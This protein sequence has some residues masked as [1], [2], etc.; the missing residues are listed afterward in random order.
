MYPTTPNDM[1]PHYLWKIEVRICDKLRTR[2]TFSW[3]VMV[4]VGISKL[5]FTDLI[6]VDPRVKINGGY[7]RSCCPWCATYQTISSSFN[8]TAHPHTRYVKTVRFLVQLTSVFIRQDLWPSNSTDINSAIYKTCGD[9]QQRV[10][11]SQLHSIDELEKRLLDVIGTKSS[12]RASLT[13]QLT[14][15]VSVFERVCRQK[16]VISSNCCKRD[17]LFIYLFIY[18]LYKSWTKSQNRNTNHTC[19]DKDDERQT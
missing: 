3:F 2:S 9:I 4:S 12:T 6:F 10:H 7:Y 1:L 13:M 5:S 14:S 18:L 16:A 8:K 19:T 11:Q 17:N 15:G